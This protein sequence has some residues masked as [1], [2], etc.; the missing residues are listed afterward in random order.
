LGLDMEIA[1]IAV[2][3][4]GHFAAFAL[5]VPIL[6]D[7]AD[8]V[9]ES[10]NLHLVKGDEEQLKLLRV[11][12]LDGLVRDGG[13]LG[14]DELHGRYT[15]VML[16]GDVSVTG[17][18]PLR[19]VATAG[20][21]IGGSLRADAGDAPAAGSGGCAGGGSAMAADC[22]DGSGK[23]GSSDATPG[24]GGGG[25]FGSEGTAGTGG[26]GQE[27][28]TSGQAFLVPLPPELTE[29]SRGAGGGGGGGATGG[30]G[31]GSGG[32]I[33]LTT[34]ATL[35]MAGDAVISASGG[36]GED[37]LC[38]TGGGG[39]G[40][41][42]GAILV[43]AGRLLVGAGARVEAR[44]GQGAGGG[45][46]VGGD[47]GDGR[48]RIDRGNDAAPDAG[49]AAFVGPAPVIAD[50]PVIVS[51]AEL[52]LPVRAKPNTSYQVFIGDRDTPVTFE[53]DGDGIGTANV[54]LEP[55]LNRLCVQVAPAADL[56]YPEAKNCVNVA[57]IEP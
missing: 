28:S 29:T 1:D 7:L 18:A 31:G 9:E 16:S 47:G 25:G 52:A 32:V 12:G 33:E 51:E 17:D 56:A 2:S 26:G 43:R 54:P 49:P 36:D 48:I 8:Q 41:S 37:L 6:E 53:T 40:G 24:G 42:G 22:G 4:D 57:Y 39:G 5:R 13:T 55:G 21:Q 20:M 14:T 11:T 45:A 34:P 38:T 19:I 10:I 46:C 44:G 23:A 30:L 35:S 15:H 50:L 27:G 3:G